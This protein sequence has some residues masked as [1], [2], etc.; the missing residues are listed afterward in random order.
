MPAQI[1]R[2]AWRTPNRRRPSSPA[3]RS[4]LPGHRSFGRASHE[5][6][7]AA[8]LSVAGSVLMQKREIG[9]LEL[10]K[11]FIPFDLFEAVFRRSKIDPE[12]TGVSVLFGSPD[13]CWTSVA[14]L[15]PF[16]DCLVI[17]SRCAVAH[18]TFLSG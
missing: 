5:L 10:A 13:R 18:S 14:L 8:Q 6:V 4:R 1:G 3:G 11:E 9:L 2:P 7:K 17:R 15:R 12:N 16:P